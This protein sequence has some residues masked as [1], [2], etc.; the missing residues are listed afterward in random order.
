M[1]NRRGVTVF[2]T[3]LPRTREAPK[4][5]LLHVCKFH[6][7]IQPAI[8]HETQEAL[9]SFW[10][11]TIPPH[12]EALKSLQAFYYFLLFILK[13]VID[14]SGNFIAQRAGPLFCHH[15]QASVR[16]ESFP[17]LPLWCLSKG[18]TPHSTLHVPIPSPG[19]CIRYHWGTGPHHVIAACPCP[20]GTQLE[21]ISKARKATRQGC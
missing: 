21:H 8:L 19:C 14:G 12:Q 13:L 20:A 10:S 3:T 9:Y 5:T 18:W 11:S 17:L 15:T 6:R 2:N 7:K 16:R 1:K 4:Q